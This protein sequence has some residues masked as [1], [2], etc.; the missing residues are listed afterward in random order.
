MKLDSFCSI[1]NPNSICLPPSV[2]ELLTD[3]I[4]AKPN[5]PDDTKDKLDLIMEEYGCND[6][7]CVLKQSNVLS[8]STKNE[9][10][11]NH[12]KPIAPVDPTKWLSNTHLD[13]LQEQLYKIYDN[14]YYSFIHMIDMK[15]IPHEYKKLL[16]HEI[17]DVT[18]ISF[19][20]E[21]KEDGSKVISK[22]DKPLKTYGVVF[23]TDPSNK[24][25]QHWF[26]IFFDFRTRGT[27]EEPFTIE[28]FNSAG[29]KLNNKVHEY[30]VSLANKISFE[31]KKICNFI[32]VTNIQHQ[33]PKT[34]NCGAYSLFY[35]YARLNNVPMSYFNNKAI[36][37]DDDKITEF[38]KLIFIDEKKVK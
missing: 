26:A 32:T 35:I 13:Q 36:T 34:G 11:F 14:Y 5:Q 22:E 1:D 7:V 6:E 17:I 15:M 27:L 16:D 31:M 10:L 37:V 9:L 25:G 20:D 3:E 18:M 19:V 8:R 2:I 4:I 28:Y 33:S 38:R 30:F 24:S 21:L 29:T 23:N 12:F